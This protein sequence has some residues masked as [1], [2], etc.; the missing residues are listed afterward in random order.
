MSHPKP[1]ISYVLSL[2]I[3]SLGHFPHTTILA[4]LSETCE[5]EVLDMYDRSS[6]TYQTIHN[7]AVMSQMTT[8]LDV[9]FSA[10]F[11]VFNGNMETLNEFTTACESY[12]S[13]SAVSTGDSSTLGGR[14]TFLSSTN[15]CTHDFDMGI[16]ACIP[17]SC[18]DSS[19]D[20]DVA[21]LLTDRP[22]PVFMGKDCSNV[23]WATKNNIHDHDYDH[24]SASSSLS[25][26][27][28][29]DILTI[30]GSAMAGASNVT[31]TD[32]EKAK[33]QS[34]VAYYDGKEHGTSV[35]QGEFR[36]IHYEMVCDGKVEKVMDGLFCVP[37]SCENR[38]FVAGALNEIT[39]AEEVNPYFAFLFFSWNW[40]ANC[41]WVYRVP[42]EEWVVENN[43]IDT[44]GG[45]GNETV[46]N[47]AE[48]SSQSGTN[49]RG[50]GMWSWAFP[51]LVA[52]LLTFLC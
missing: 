24:T 26:S 50:I 34:C 14:V 40:R 12:Q 44:P 6:L 52:L 4:Q 43:A 29:E 35:I 33:G 17:S 42:E 37:S 19:H 28:M 8:K 22:T 2:V 39:Y 3:C 18:G 9:P 36:T 7:T 5:M 48:S 27:C 16:P 49:P 47:P 11:H 1:F 30:A 10:N 13:S 21:A 25:T 31:A 38:E 15:K 20:A 51:A 32:G 41:K 46:I 23:F 45:N